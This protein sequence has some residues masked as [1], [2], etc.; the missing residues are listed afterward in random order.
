VTTPASTAENAASD[1]VRNANLA[2]VRTVPI[3]RPS[4]AAPSDAPMERKM[5]A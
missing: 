3:N 5:T 1:A 4:S 2:G